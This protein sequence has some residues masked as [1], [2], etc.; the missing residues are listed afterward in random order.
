MLK[1]YIVH[2][3]HTLQP[4]SAQLIAGLAATLSFKLW[5]TDIKQA[6]LQATEPQQRRVFI[7]NPAPKFELERKEC[8]ELLRLL[9]G[10]ADAGDLWHRSLENH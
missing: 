9:Y 4:T 6:Y 5:S 10:L 8:F 3:A 2:N 1:L 7:N